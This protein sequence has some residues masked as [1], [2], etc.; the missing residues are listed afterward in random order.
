[1]IEAIRQVAQIPTERR[2]WSVATIAAFLE[3]SGNYTANEIVNRPDF[4]RPAP[5]FHVEPITCVEIGT[6]A[7]QP[8]RESGNIAGGDFGRKG[9]TAGD[10]FHASPS[11][12]SFHSQLMASNTA[13]VPSR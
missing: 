9:A 11:G 5:K 10:A 6:S 13:C 12:D 4:P 7:A 2:Y 8:Y 3:Y 1:M